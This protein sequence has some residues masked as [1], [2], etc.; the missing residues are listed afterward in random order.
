MARLQS[1]IGP[2]FNIQT[3]LSGKNANQNYQ[4]HRHEG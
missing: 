3:G 1:G 2:F 4:K